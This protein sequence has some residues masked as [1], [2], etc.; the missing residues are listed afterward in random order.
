MKQ[1]RRNKPRNKRRSKGI[2]R[3]PLKP[4]VFYIDLKHGI[5]V[6]AL[7]KPVGFGDAHCPSCGNR[8]VR[9]GSTTGYRK[10]CKNRVQKYRCIRCGR[11][12]NQNTSL[13][14]LEKLVEKARKAFG[15][16]VFGRIVDASR[17]SGI[18]LNTLYTLID[19]ALETKPRR[20]RADRPIIYI[21]DSGFGRYC[22]IGVKAGTHVFIFLLPSI[23]YLT[24]KTALRYVRRYLGCIDPVVVSDGAKCYIDAVRNIFPD[25][26]HVRQFHRKRGVVYI[27]FRHL[28]QVY[29][30][31]V[32]W[33]VFLEDDGDGLWAR[34]VAR[35]D[36]PLQSSDHAYLYIGAKKNP[37]RLPCKRK[38]RS[39]RKRRRRRRKR[40]NS[41]A[42]RVFAGSLEDLFERYSFC[43]DVFNR[44][45]E[46]FRGRFI[47]S[48]WAEWCF[49]AKGYVCMFG[50]RG[51]AML[52]LFRYYFYIL[53]AFRDEYSRDR[54]AMKLAIK[55]V[56]NYKH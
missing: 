18:S 49:Q 53:G 13:E 3:Y 5:D 10:N 48:N 47:T 56:K 16:M 42:K 32:R 29:T 15:K 44:V 23:N 33:D 8:G 28:E 9:K 21:D 55:A 54:L 7:P 45:G 12:F 35:I 51:R 43:R 11:S 46:A 34:R 20:I 14:A 36:T 52:A 38:R 6:R 4:R 1:K 30:L 2:L 25:A 22:M 19:K 31:I 37:R 27:H 24:A 17:E 26:I 50:I 39:R 40:R 41:Y